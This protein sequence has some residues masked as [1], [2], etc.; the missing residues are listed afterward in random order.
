MKKRVPKEV[1]KPASPD[2][3]K[4]AAP[5]DKVFTESTVTSG[6]IIVGGE[7]VAKL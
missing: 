2:A 6:G 3:R 7:H 4:K 5:I 1:P